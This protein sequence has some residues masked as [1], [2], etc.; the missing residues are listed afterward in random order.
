MRLALLLLPLSCAPAGAE[1]PDEVAEGA[2]VLVTAPATSPAG[3]PLPAA[4]QAPD[5]SLAGVTVAQAFPPPEGAEQVAPS[6]FGAWLQER[7]L[8]DA[9][10]P[11]LTYDGRVVRHRGRV[12][13][14]PHVEGD[15]Q[16][17]ADAILRL[18]AEWLREEGRP[19]SIYATSGDPIPW[20]RYQTGER[21]RVEGRHLAWT[22]GHGPA[23]WDAY[24]SAAFN[25]AG[26][27]SLKAHET[28][29]VTEP[30]PGDILVEAGSPGHA[31]LLMDV[32]READGTTWVLMGE[33]YMPAQ[34]FHVE[35]GPKDGWWPLD[36]AG[37]PLPH[38]PLERAGLRRWKGD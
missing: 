18:R 7:L 28:R 20:S 17:C 34:D 35:L 5:L 32:A 33:S 14:L 27:I 29:A 2:P 23:T 8:E 12:V 22:G 16:Q 30:Q 25:W 4:P 13:Q 9:A 10:A 36:E 6:P 37:L 24:L 19:V 1:P 21:P 15:L 31:V 3:P 38:W 26:T 11:V